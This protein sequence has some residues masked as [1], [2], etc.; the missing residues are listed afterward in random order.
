MSPDNH[1]TDMRS[2]LM[3]VLKAIMSGVNDPV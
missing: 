3:T 2:L 1:S